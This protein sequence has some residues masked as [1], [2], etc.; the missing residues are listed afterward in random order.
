MIGI[1]TAAAHRMS[2][3]INQALVDGYCFT[4]L[5]VRLRDG[6]TD[7][8]HY[9]FRREAVKHQI[10]ERLC[11]YI[12]VQPNGA[13]PAICQGALNF[14]RFAYDSGHRITDPEQPDYILPTTNEDMQDKL[15]R[16]LTEGKK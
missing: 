2:D 13:N 16:L 8:V 14:Y 4:W 6:G 15:T 5:A 1:P 11:A 12:L 9:Q 10:D 7:G 3:A